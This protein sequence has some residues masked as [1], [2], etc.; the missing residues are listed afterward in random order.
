[1]KPTIIANLQGSDG[2][3]FALMGIAS[4][5]LSRE[6]SQTMFTEVT[7]C[8]NYDDAVNAIRKYVDIVDEQEIVATY[9][10]HIARQKT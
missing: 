7:A 2:N 5:E 9:M 10:Q 3:I 8:S 4:K 6:E 1:V